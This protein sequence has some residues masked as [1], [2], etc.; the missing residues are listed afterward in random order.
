[1]ANFKILG[2]MLLVVGTSIGGGMLALP[3][4]TATLGFMGATAFLITAWALM[5][6]GALLLLEVNLW[7][8]PKT[9]LISMSHKTLGFPGQAIAWVAYLLLLYSLL[10]AYISGGGDV[11]HHLL[12][13]LG[14]AISE[15]VSAVLFVVLVSSIVYRGIKAV[16]HVNRYLMITKLVAFIVL[17]ACVFPFVDLHKITRPQL[18]FSMAAIVIV[19]TSFGFASIVPSL[20]VYYEDDVKALKKV[21]FIGSL[22]PLVCYIAW[23][24]V[25]HGV[26][27]ESELFSMLEQGHTTSALMQALSA[28][29]HNAWLKTSADLFVSFSVVTSFLGVSLGLSD[30]LAD[31]LRMPKEGKKKKYVFL[32]TF[33]P[34]LIIV[35]FNQN[36]FLKGLDYAG[37]CCIVLLML[38]PS[39]MAWFGRYHKKIATGYRVK[40]GRVVLIIM[41]LAAV[42]LV[43]F[44]FN[45][46]LLSK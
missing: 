20:R 15:Q 22:I 29:S 34:P 19:I 36:I 9:N 23:I 26:L 10:A 16:D 13:P 3:V 17:V 30:F 11:L 1:M 5:T 37:V 44:G 40:G 35:L 28:V 43:L 24:W 8:P 7:L 33:L 45:P 4:A 6:Y 12:Q 14:L 38:L 41:M 27:S 21:I 32:L 2:G 31:G 39:L 46:A 18:S 42:L 25:I